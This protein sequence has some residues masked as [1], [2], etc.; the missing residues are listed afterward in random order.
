[1]EPHIPV[2]PP[3]LLFLLRLHVNFIREE[4]TALSPACWC[5]SVT[6]TYGRQVSCELL[7]RGQGRFC[8]D[9]GGTFHFTESLELTG[10][11]DPMQNSKLS[12]VCGY[13]AIKLSG[14]RPQ[15]I[16]FWAEEL[17]T[18]LTVSPPS[19]ESMETVWEC[20]LAGWQS[21]CLASELWWCAHLF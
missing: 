12:S 7:G 9:S 18:A 21:A 4:W 20:S 8:R 5:K 14:Q 19:E 2:F 17:I 11:G 3:T 1:M 15:A 6:S 13:L 10:W 16:S